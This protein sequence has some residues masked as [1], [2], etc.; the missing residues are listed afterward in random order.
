MK[1]SLIALAALATV[2]AAQAQSSV[3][4]YG[5]FDAAY[6][7][8]DYKNVGGVDSTATKVKQTGIAGSG[9]LSSQRFGFR[10]TED[11]GGGLRANFNL[12]YG[13]TS[14]LLDGATTASVS[15]TSS[16]T[17]STAATSQS[18][19]AIGGQLVTR[20]SRVGL[21][22][23]KFGRVD[24]GYGLTGLFATVTGHSPLP[25]NNF[26]GDVAYTSN[27]TSSADHRIMGAPLS[28]TSGATRMSGAQ[29]TS[30][31]V[32][33]LQAVIDY[34]SG[35]Q[36]FTNDTTGEDWGVQNAGLTLR[37]NVGKLGLAGTTHK[38]KS[39]LNSAANTIHN[40]DYRALSARY[41]VTGNL[42]LN[43]LYASNKASVQGGSQAA[44][45]D[46]T[47]VGVSY[48]MGKNQFVAQ[49]G[50]GE[51]EGSASNISKRDRKGYQL[52]AI[53]S[54]SKR[55]S[56]YALYGN[57]EAVYVTNASGA[58]QNVTEKVSGYAVGLRHSF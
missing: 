15:T 32:N 35:N 38:L 43:A 37:Y 6:N 33:G 16:S 39:E 9:P 24:V 48:T 54:L 36:K 53:H 22:S 23:A 44:K 52:G 58:A 47:Q 41:A 11:L 13:F 57:Q 56:V 4:V 10:G 30:P 55:T 2:G 5:V 7:A 50:E 14:A 40:I 49:Y 12:E 27:G 18:N 3:T 8:L 51:G 26:I 17:D 1:K 29:Y 28:G 20:T 21:E 45:N 42:A 34:G 31:T 46:V 19:Q 25:G